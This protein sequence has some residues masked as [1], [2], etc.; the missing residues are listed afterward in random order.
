[1]QGQKNKFDV[2]E[3]FWVTEEC[4]NNRLI[5]F[6]IWTFG[7]AGENYFCHNHFSLVDRSRKRVWKRTTWRWIKCLKW[8][9]KEFGLSGR[10]TRR[11]IEHSCYIQFGLDL[12]KSS[13]LDLTYYFLKTIDFILILN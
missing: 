9:T 5:A 3:Y 2:F 4:S 7:K 6:I 13:M 12:K 10:D 11:W 8:F 1:M